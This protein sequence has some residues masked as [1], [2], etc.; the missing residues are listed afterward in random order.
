VVKCKTI[1][2]EVPASAE[3]VLEGEV[4]PHIRET[5]GPFGE[6]T[7]YMGG[8]YDLPLFKI[9]CITHRKNP[10]YQ[11]FHSQK[12]P[13]EST[14]IRQMAEEAS[15]YKHLVHQLKIPGIIDVHCP[16]AGGAYAMLWIRLDV[17]YHGHAKQ[18]LTAAWTH[19]P[20]FAKWIAVTDADIDIRDP[21]SREWAMSWRVEPIKDIY[22]IPDTASIMLDPSC[23]PMDVQ[24][25]DRKS[26]KIC[27]D[28]TKKWEYPP[29]AYPPQEHM[30]KVKNDWK[31]YGID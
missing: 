4:L 2:V 30:Q 25:W 24:L 14:L 21:F 6:Y 18:V 27:I 8:P 5:E 28:A 15:V 23:A 19:A 13:S 12:P 31:K 29:I 16:D 26:S 9:K 1:D 7:G 10:I 11:A 22:F 3:I 20:S 17:K